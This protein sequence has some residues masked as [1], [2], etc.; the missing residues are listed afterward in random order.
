LPQRWFEFSQQ[1]LRGDLGS[2]IAISFTRADSSTDLMFIF[3]DR[4][5]PG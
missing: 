2:N 3:G 1:E 5:G 4:D